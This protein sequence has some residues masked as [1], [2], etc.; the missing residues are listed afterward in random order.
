MENEKVLTILKDL[1]YAM[2]ELDITTF[3]NGRLEIYYHL[4]DRLD[5]E[6]KLTKLVDQVAVEYLTG[7]HN[8][9]RLVDVIEDSIYKHYDDMW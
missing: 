1:I 3:G 7:D 9:D 4:K 8:I 2:I 6:N 5:E